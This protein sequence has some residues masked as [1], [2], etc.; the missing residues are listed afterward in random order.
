MAYRVQ[1]PPDLKRH[2]EVSRSLSL[3][4]NSG[5]GGNDG[6]NNQPIDPTEGPIVAVKIASTV[7]EADI[8]LAFDEGFKPDEGEP[9]AVFYVHE[10]PLLGEKTSEQ[11]REIHKVKLALGPGSRVRQ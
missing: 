9:L 10:L 7:F 11:L 3:P 6:K 2:S 1:F 5:K 4:K 8:W